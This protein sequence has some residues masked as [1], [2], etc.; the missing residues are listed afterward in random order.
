MSEQKKI[1]E[2]QLSGGGH[3]SPLC[4]VGD[5]GLFHIFLA[6]C[7]ICLTAV[8]LLLIFTFC[9]LPLLLG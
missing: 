8:V 9:T 4:R 6:V 1:D 3:Y 5:T 2:V 7:A